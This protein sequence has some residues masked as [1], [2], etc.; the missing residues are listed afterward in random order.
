MESFADDLE[1]GYEE[2]RSVVY[3]TYGYE[4]YTACPDCLPSIKEDI[5]NQRE[6]DEINLLEEEYLSRRLPH[7]RGDLP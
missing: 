7:L 1:T 5:Q 2:G 6:Q 3:D 4:D